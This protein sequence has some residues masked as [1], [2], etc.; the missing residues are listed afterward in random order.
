MIKLMEI[1]NYSLEEILDRLTP[2]QLLT[3]I[4]KHRELTG[5]IEFSRAKGLK[6]VGLSPMLLNQIL[7]GSGLKVQT[8]R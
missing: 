4:M 1:G 3:I 2:L 6:P 5:S 8:K 7:E